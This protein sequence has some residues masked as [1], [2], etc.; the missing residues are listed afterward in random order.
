[1]ADDA[2]AIRTAR[3]ACGQTVLELRGAP[4][5]TAICYCASC[6]RAGAG[7][8][9][10]PGAPRVLQ[11]DGGTPFTLYRKDRVRFLSGGD[12]L[13]EHR[14]SSG[15]PTRRVVANCCNSAMFLEFKGGHWLS[16]YRDRLGTDAAPIDV[17]V[18]TRAKRP[19]VAFSDGIPSFATHNIGF[20]WKLLRGWAA[21]G[22]KVPKTIDGV[23]GSARTTAA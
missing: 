4:I 23:R 6:Q 5:V 1:M 17:R 22:F 15:A 9:A 12:W 8:E 13:E 7:L 2:N 16:V 10:L 11:D 3:C 14:L 20:M 18:M 19:D 21:M